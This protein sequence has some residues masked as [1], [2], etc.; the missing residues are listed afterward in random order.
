M[1]TFG[2]SLENV[3]LPFL[4]TLVPFLSFTIPMAFMFAVLIS[5]SRLSSDGEFTAMLAA[6]YSLRRA[7]APVFIISVCLYLIGAFCSLNFEAWG[8]RETVKF[9]HRKTQTQLDNMIKVKM[10]SGVFLDDFL[11]YVLYAEEISPDKTHFKNVLMAPGKGRGN[12]NFTLMAPEGALTGSVKSGDLKMSFK[13]G[14]FYT[15][16]LTSDKISVVKFKDTELDILRIF[17]EQIFGRDSV[18]HDYRS[19]PPFKLWK[20][21][22]QIRNDENKKKN[23]Y[24]AH[25]LI[26]SRIGMAF[27]VIPF[28]LIALVLGIQDERKGKGTGYLGVILTIIIGYV[29]TMSFKWIAEKGMIAA[30]L[31]VWI[32]NLI[33]LFF[34]FFLVYQRNRL[35]PSEST[36]DPRYIPGIAKLIKKS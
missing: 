2:L 24:K 31:G 30:P 4:F 14:I 29:F 27:S 32:P 33:L 6:G 26:H 17:R 16:G 5:F 19:F 11:G 34:S 18:N 22:D 35:P 9:Y 20:Y 7:A 1:V 36:L 12:Q 15:S 3:L 21:V 8:R 23:F 10:K 25:Y 28:A 13:N